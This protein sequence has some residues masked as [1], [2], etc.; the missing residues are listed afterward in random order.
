MNLDV[1]ALFSRLLQLV[2]R[3]CMGRED[4][5]MRFDEIIWRGVGS[6]K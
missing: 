4:G 3:A 6:M 2:R 1:W 5:V